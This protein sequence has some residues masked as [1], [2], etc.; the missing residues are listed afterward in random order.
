MKYSEPKRHLTDEQINDYLNSLKITVA[1]SLCPRCGT[2]PKR[3]EDQPWEC[4]C[5][6]LYQK[7]CPFNDMESHENR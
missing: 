7:V 2:F 4:M 6:I 1:T 3:C 5:T